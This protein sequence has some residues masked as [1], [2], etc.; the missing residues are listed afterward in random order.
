MKKDIY[1]ILA[2]HAHE[3]IWDLPGQLQKGVTD[4][5]IAQGIL[6]E[7][8][9]RKRMQEGRNIYRDLIDFA[10][11]LK[12]PVTLDITNEL[13]FQLG[14]IRPDSFSILKEAYSSGLIYPLYTMAHHTHICLMNDDEIQEEV[15]LNEEFIHDIIGAPRP[16]Y[17]GMFF[18]ECSI[19]ENK[20]KAAKNLDI[21]YIIFPHITEEKGDYV[22]SDEI[23]EYI[24]KPFKVKHNITALPRNFPVS[25]YIWKPITRCVPEKVKCQGFIMGQYNVFSEEYRNKEHL[26]FP[27]S[28]EE[29]INEY[30]EVLIEQISLAP[31]SG[32]I[33]YIQDLE[34]MDFGDCALQI[35]NAAW[36]KVQEMDI[37]NIHFVTPDEY[38]DKCVKSHDNIPTLGFKKVS[39]APEIRVLLRY[40]GHYPPIDYG[41]F[42]GHKSSTDSVFKKYPFIFWEQGRFLTGL[43]DWL[44]KM[45]MTLSLRQI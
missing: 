22:F 37:A 43:F 2:F 23:N 18:T 38:I 33:L 5:R 15:R 9:V 12:A 3:P 28:K 30:T 8:Y 44:L 26:D 14:R 6:P 41:E 16:R 42:R 34:L 4:Q 13:L 24:F 1:I 32:L 10:G 27:I 7:N 25:Q 19:D 39:W 31:D 17:R 35:A 11:D 40:D 21:D 20:L 45:Y 36:K 29:A